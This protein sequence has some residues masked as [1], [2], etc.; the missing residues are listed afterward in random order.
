VFRSLIFFLLTAHV[1]QPAPAT[2]Q[3]RHTLPERRRGAARLRQTPGPGGRGS[4]ETPTLASRTVNL[5]Q[6]ARPETDGFCC[7]ECNGGSSTC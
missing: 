7:P 5:L 6:V 4:T 3:A 2:T 1:S